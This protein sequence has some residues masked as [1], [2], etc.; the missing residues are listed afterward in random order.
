MCSRFW[1]GRNCIRRLDGLL[2]GEVSKSDLKLDGSAGRG[3][4][5]Q[6]HLLHEHLG[7]ATVFSVVAF[8]QV[9]LR[10]DCLPQEHLACEA[11]TQPSPERPQQVVGTVMMSFEVVSLSVLVMR[12][13]AGKVL[14]VLDWIVVKYAAALIEDL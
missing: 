11:Q 6:I 7:P 1:H 8:S 12:A 13:E 10:A 2:G 5:A 4:Y 3:E 9:Q 14:R